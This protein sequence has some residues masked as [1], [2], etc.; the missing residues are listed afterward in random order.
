[1]LAR[2]RYHKVLQWSADRRPAISS[3]A[4]C[5]RLEPSVQLDRHKTN[6]LLP[7]RI[8][9]IELHS[10]TGVS[11]SFAFQWLALAF[12][13]V[14]QVYFI[15]AAL[16]GGLGQRSI[17]TQHASV[18]QVVVTPCAFLLSHLKTV[19]FSFHFTLCFTFT[20][21]ITSSSSHSSSRKLKV[22][23]KL[24]SYL[25]SSHSSRRK[26]KAIDELSSS[27]S[28]STYNYPLTTTTYLFY[29]PR[30]T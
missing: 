27:L 14:T 5:E 11:R 2:S 1:M 16:S 15:N 19:C 13:E 10:S 4:S 18:T 12:H 9:L 17:Q 28:S 25:S 7:R 3:A 20:F 26:V 30:R 23:E 8:L 6:K 24:S 29:Q 22:I 21:F